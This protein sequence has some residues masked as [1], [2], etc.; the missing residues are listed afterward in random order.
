[1]DTVPDL[2][3][4]FVDMTDDL[5]L[6]SRVVDARP[7]Y[8]PKAGDYAVV[9]DEDADSRVARIVGIDSHGIIDLE[10]LPGAVEDHRDLLA[11]T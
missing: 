4:D 5:R 8:V 6:I 10:V 11:S 7:G 2:V 3:V 1:M 9:G